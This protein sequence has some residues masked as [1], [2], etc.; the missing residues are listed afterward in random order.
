M[1]VSVVVIG[2]NEGER[3]TRCLTSVRASLGPAAVELI[4]VDS[5]SSDDS[6]QRAASLC[7]QVLVVK[8]ERPCAAIGRNAGWRQAQGEFVLFLDGD[9]V[10]HPNF[11]AQALVAMERIDIA[12]VW[13]HRRELDPG[14]SLWTGVMDLDWVYAPGETAYC[15]GDVLMRR[16]VLQQLNG[17]DETLIAGEEPELCRR[18]RAAGFCILHIDAPMT[19]HDLAIR[20]FSQYWTRAVRAGHAYAEIA[21]RFRDS[22]DP[23]WS[24]VVRG[25]ARKGLFWLLWLLALGLLPLIQPMLLLPV[26]MV[27]AL[28]SLR[29]ALKVRWK[30]RIAQCSSL[31]LLAYGVH[32]HLQHV[33]IFWGQ[34]RYRVGIW[35]GRQSRLMEYK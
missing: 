12:A 14:Q 13:G 35:Q 32:S 33:P 8:P 28:A 17:F 15:G 19:G 3:L 11:L 1:Q 25:N 30:Q 24:D 4:Y 20:H 26:L 22:V 7:D 23:L 21:S 10:L 2:R 9:T 31:R 34:L 27:L 6:L 5:A 29:T 16:S 18:I